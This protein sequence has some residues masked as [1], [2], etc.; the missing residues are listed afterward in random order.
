MLAGG[1]FGVAG[2]HHQRE[3]ALVEVSR[4]L[5]CLPCRLL[6]QAVEPVFGGVSTPCR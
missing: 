6:T 5:R 3:E 2:E 4:S 1:G